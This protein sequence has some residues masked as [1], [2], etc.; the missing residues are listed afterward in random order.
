MQS[1]YS[2]ARHVDQIIELINEIADETNLLALNATI[3]AAGAGEFGRRFAVIA[4][5]VQL[6]A[7]RSR[8]ATRQVQQVVL[9]V[10][11]SIQTSSE[12]A[13]Q[14]STEAAKA[15]TGSRSMEQTLEG[16]IQMVQHTARLSRQISIAIQQQRGATVQL[17]ETVHHVSTISKDVAHDSK[18]LLG[19]F[20]SLDEA[21]SKLSAVAI[22]RN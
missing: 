4:N 19:S 10:R 17:V 21:V 14:G 20:Y 6:L 3:E 16:I 22:Q 8:L 12:I 18:E 7:N 1:V 5:E 11:N 15:M 13:A 2:K 9:E